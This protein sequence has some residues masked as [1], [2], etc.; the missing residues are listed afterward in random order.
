MRRLAI[1]SGVAALLGC[2]ASCAHTSGG[3]P[4]KNMSVA[5]WRTADRNG[6]ALQ[7][8][9]FPEAR[10][11]PELRRKENLG[12]AISGGGTRSSVAALGQFRGLRK[13]GLLQKARYISAI[14]GGA[15]LATPYVYAHADAVPATTEHSGLN[16]AQ[17]DE[18]FLGRYCPPEALHLTD[19]TQ[20]QH[21]SFVDTVTR[22]DM[23]LACGLRVFEGRGDETYAHA[24]NEVFLQPFGLGDEDRFFAWSEDWLRGQ[25]LPHN[26]SLTPEQFYFEVPDRPFLIVSESLM[27]E[28]RLT[29]VD[30]VLL[31]LRRVGLPFL[32]DLD[33]K[34]FWTV[35]STPLY[36]GL[37]P[38]SRPWEKGARLR[39]FLEGPAGGGLVESFGYD[40]CFSNWEDRGRGGSPSRARVAL[41]QP[42]SHR[43]GSVYSLADMLA[44]SGA[45]P[46]A[47]LGG[48]TG[49][50]GQL[51]EFT[52]WPAYADQPGQHNV[53]YAHVDGGACD[54]TG[55]I[56]LLARRVD[57]IIALLNYVP[58]FPPRPNQKPDR[59]D[60]PS[61]VTC[62]FGERGDEMLRDA[63]GQAVSNQVLE[64]RLPGGTCATDDLA[65]ALVADN[66]A[67]RPLVHCQHYVT[68]ANSRYG[69]PG[70]HRVTICWVY[71]V[72]G[73][74]AKVSAMKG[75]QLESWIQQLPDH[76]EPGARHSVRDMF[77]DRRLIHRYGLAH[78]PKFGVVMENPGQF[79]KLT[80]VQAQALAHYT[81]FCVHE[82]GPEIRTALGW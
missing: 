14:S 72:P 15:W 79:L 20:T 30:K 24:L 65:Q 49:A 7:D 41:E 28:M 62:L 37:R 57:K 60:L 53:E 64:S 12:I 39:G 48:V 35:E 75:T 52:H 59:N 19:L 34:G 68:V 27:R 42:V 47:F 76:S 73:T 44:A 55:I 69:V 66:K 54:N 50:T 23:P 2:L 8:F 58:P 81:S 21:G 74:L 9:A 70:G 82:A 29:L 10:L 5:V 45:A 31:M 18:V 40:T 63:I 17:W 1:L 36:T 67:G 6:R 61:M 77:T 80:A 25:I 3:S 46:A 38:V 78:F 26:P 11:L 13:L 16:Q 4:A 56:P 32:P 43:R 51:P 22:I 71:L 33:T